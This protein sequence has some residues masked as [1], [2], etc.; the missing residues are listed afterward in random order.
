MIVQASIDNGHG[1]SFQ[2]AVALEDL[3]TWMQGWLDRGVMPVPGVDV[4]VML[5][6]AGEMDVPATIAQRRHDE[7]VEAYNNVALAAIRTR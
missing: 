5:R 3:G 4:V 2:A 6:F 7:I 1:R